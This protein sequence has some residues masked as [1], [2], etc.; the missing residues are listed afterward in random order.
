MHNK[1]PLTVVEWAAVIAAGSALGMQRVLNV[2]Y[3]AL[4]DLQ[5]RLADQQK[6]I[7]DLQKALSDQQNSPTYIS[8]GGL[9]FERDTHGMYFLIREKGT[10]HYLSTCCAANTE[11]AQLQL[12]YRDQPDHVLKS[13]VLAQSSQTN[14]SKLKPFLRR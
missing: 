4:L 6:T 3:K 11:G 10:V 5:K 8:S 13:M 9:G 1:E 12:W 7:L 2:A 14:I